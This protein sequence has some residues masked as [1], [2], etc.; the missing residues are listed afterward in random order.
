MAA[1]GQI[2][3]YFLVTT[4]CDF[5]AH[6]K[7]MALTETY[8]LNTYLYHHSL[9]RKGRVSVSLDCPVLEGLILKKV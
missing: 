6:T 4:C 8:G 2:S 7:L 1:N 9:A 3:D 5:T